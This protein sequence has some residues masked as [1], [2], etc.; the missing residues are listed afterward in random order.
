[1]TETETK[2]SER[3]REWKSSGRTAKEFAE[4]RDFKASTLVYWASCLRTGIGGAPRGKKREPRKRFMSLAHLIDEVALQR[5]YDN[6]RADAA[7]GMDGTTKEQYGQDLE[8]K[9][10][11]LHQ[12]L[13]SKTWRH[14]PIRRVHIPK[15]QGKTRPIGI[16]SIE[17]KIVQQA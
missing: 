15:E 10:R 13:R 4:G 8:V 3:V 12:R 2:W 5:A 7:V 11:D 9:L 16:S 14:Q 17:D 6:I 1:M